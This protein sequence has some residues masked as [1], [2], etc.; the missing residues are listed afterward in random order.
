M[1]TINGD[2][3]EQVKELNFL[4][5]TVD[6]NVT[7]DAHITKCIQYSYINITTSLEIIYSYHTFVLLP[8][9]ITKT[10]TLMI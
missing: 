2:I 3:I 10:T 9:I 7:W 8:H 1:L 4:G 6:Q 5:I